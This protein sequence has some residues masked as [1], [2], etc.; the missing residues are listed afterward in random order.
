[1]M[2]FEDTG[3]LGSALSGQQSPEPADQSKSSA[4]DATSGGGSSG[5]G[6]LAGGSVPNCSTTGSGSEGVI[7]HSKKENKKL[8]ERAAIFSLSRTSRGMNGTDHFHSGSS[9]VTGNHQ[10][11]HQHRQNIDRPSPVNSSSNSRK[12]KSPSSKSSRRTTSLL[13][14]FVASTSVSGMWGLWGA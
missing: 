8:R 6:V 7:K 12:S 4:E 3:S 10:H 9:A 11:N 5:G 13:N 2:V 1:M 14:L